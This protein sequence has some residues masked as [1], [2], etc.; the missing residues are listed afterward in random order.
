[1]GACLTG[2]LLLYRAAGKTAVVVVWEGRSPIGA[3]DQQ[4]RRLAK[5]RPL[6]APT[7][8]RAVRVMRL[9]PG[10]YMIAGLDHGGA[11]LYALYLPAAIEPASPLS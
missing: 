10:A 7:G 6:P 2:R 9:V 5:P 8:R 3:F 4:L 11:E 1:L